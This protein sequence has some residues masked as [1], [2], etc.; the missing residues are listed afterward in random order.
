M[1]KSIG[2]WILTALLIAGVLS[3]VPGKLGAQR[4]RRLNVILIAL[5]QLRADQLHCL[6]NPRLTSPNLDRLAAAGVRFSHFYSVAPWT[7]PS[8]S[9]LM[10]SLFPSRHG[11]TL[12]WHPDYSLISP[13][14]PMLAEAFKAQGYYT[15]AFVNNGVAGKALTGRGFDEYDQGQPNTQVK[16]ITQ[17]GGEAYNLAPETTAKLLPW[18]DQHRTQ[19]FFLF[20]LF[21]E[22]HSPYNPPPEDDIFK[23]N[24][25]P[26]ETNTGYDLNKGH[27]FRLAMLGDQQAVQ[28]L[29][30]LYDGKIH[31]ADRY[32]GELMDQ[33]R[34]L[35]LSNSTLIVLT[36][37]HGE[38]LYSHP[39]DFLTFDHRSLY[40]TVLH[41]PLIMAGLGL[42]K[43]KLVAGLASNVDTAP[44]ILKLAGLPPLPDAEGQSLVPLIQGKEKAVNKYIYAEEDVVVPLR[45]IRTE[46]FKLIE[47]LWS[48]RCQLFDLESDPG[49][50]HDISG[51]NPSVESD[52]LDH[53]H[54]WM[55]ENHASLAERLATWRK[56]AADPRARET[57]TDDQTIGGRLLITG[58]GWHSDE[59]P[60]HGGYGGG[61]LWTEG[62][63]GSRT[64]VWRSDLPLI[65]AYKVY[66][67]YG[68]P[69]VGPLATNAPFTIATDGETGTATVDFTQ[70]AGNWVL[71]GT[72]KNPRN[73]QL[74][75]AADGVVIADAVKFERIGE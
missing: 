44:T 53:L 8:Y 15:A 61:Y 67:Y 2:S 13:D 73:V 10:T 6:G 25:Y 18:L 36:S 32:V 4:P 72:Y 28:R 41:V 38:L 50:L 58:G 33:V 9:S 49:E 42:P 26:N 16:D 17:R 48:G 65:G 74:T 51:H 43:G 22:P 31:F 68:H 7:A 69:T 57:V 40:D 1:R 30:D 14:V 34:K 3:M 70:G 21:L 64:A 56:Y 27:L 39:D 11:V 62:G 19:P 60:A 59:S 20:V 47:N 55:S 54:A 66:V 52:L 23:T 46:K 35:G 24:A 75:N 71:L 12:F 29:Y 63:D 45:S 37:D 5:D